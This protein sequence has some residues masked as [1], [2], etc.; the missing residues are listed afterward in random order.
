[1]SHPDL[2]SQPN[3]TQLTANATGDWDPRVKKGSGDITKFTSEDRLATENIWNNDAFSQSSLELCAPGS[4]C[5]ASSCSFGSQRW[6]KLKRWLCHKIWL[7]MVH[8]GNSPL[9]ILSQRHLNSVTAGDRWGELWPSL[10][11]EKFITAT[12]V[13][14]E[15]LLYQ[16]ETW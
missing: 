11:M 6:I 16:L 9:K 13:S 14:F 12:A 3:L 1:M 15:Q 7:I 4:Y 10:E 2:N 5:S 8:R